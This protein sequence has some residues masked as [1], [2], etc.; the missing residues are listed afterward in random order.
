VTIH[1]DIEE[2]DHL[3]CFFVEKKERVENVGATLFLEYKNM[4][5]KQLF[6]YGNSET[7]ATPRS[8]TATLE[9]DRFRHHDDAVWLLSASIDPQRQPHKEQYKV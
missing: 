6:E 7:E 2:W 8:S 9:S 1:D 5:P 3:Q 4:L